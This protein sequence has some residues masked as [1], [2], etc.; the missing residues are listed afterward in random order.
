MPGALRWFSDGDVESGRSSGIGNV[1]ATLE[2]CLPEVQV[3][4]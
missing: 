4:N 2:A 1:A 3:N